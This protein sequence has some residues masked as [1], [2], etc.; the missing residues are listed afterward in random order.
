[1]TLSDKRVTKRVFGDSVAYYSEEAVKEFIKE[2][3]DDLCGEVLELTDDSKWAEC[4]RIPQG[5]ILEAIQR[6]AGDDLT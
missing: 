4:D 2:L 1:M 3:K 5:H 6:L